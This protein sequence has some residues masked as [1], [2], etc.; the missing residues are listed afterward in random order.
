MKWKIEYSKQAIKFVNQ[1]EIIS[2]IKKEIKKFLLKMTG[3]S[4]NLNTKKLKGAWEGY[5][6]IRK[7]KIRILFLIDKNNKIIYIEKV[8]FRGDIYK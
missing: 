8:D 4:V 6:R 3:E 7:G 5:L 1:H 2:T